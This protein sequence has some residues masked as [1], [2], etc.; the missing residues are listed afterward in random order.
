MNNKNTQS[1]VKS[2]AHKIRLGLNLNNF[3]VNTNISHYPAVYM[4]SGLDLEFPLVLR[5]RRIIMI[6]PIFSEE[7]NINKIIQKIHKYDTS[8]FSHKKISIFHNHF[9]FNFDFGSGPE[10]VNVDLFAKTYQ[11]FN[12]LSPIGYIIEFNNNLDHCLHKPDLLERLVVNGLIVDNTDSPLKK[13]S[14]TIFE[15]IFYGTNTEKS[16]EKR[17]SG[18]GLNTI[19]L[20]NIPFSVYQK[21]KQ[22]NKL[23]SVP[24]V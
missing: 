13:T 3:I 15:K 12:Y 14:S 10:L 16:E 17:A 22:S 9:T 5:A 4:A 11:E 8:G 1:K 6:D 23:L 20:E 2:N 18:V 24:Q 19:R 21:V 7:E